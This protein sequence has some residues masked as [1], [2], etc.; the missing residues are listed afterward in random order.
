MEAENGTPAKA[1]CD[2]ARQWLKDLFQR[3]AVE[4]GVGRAAALADELMVVY[5]GASLA[6]DVDHNL[7]APAVAK[8]MAKAMLDAALAS[9]KKAA[10]PTKV[11]A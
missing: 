6:C 10:K 3:L 1:A 2:E 11:H 5:D 7:G 9:S 8:R 4:A